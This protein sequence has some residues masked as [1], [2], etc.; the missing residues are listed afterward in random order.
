MAIKNMTDKGLSFP[1]IGIIRKG[2]KKE[3]NGPGKDLPYF[4]VDFAEHE[5]KSAADFAAGYA[6]KDTGLLQPRTIRIILP[7]NEI[8]RQ[9]DA[10]YE[11]YTAGRMVARSDGEKIIYQCA[12]DGT[13]L[14]KDG[15]EVATG[16]PKPHPE[17]MFAGNDYKGKGVKFKAV[18]RLNVIIPELKRAA[19]LTLQTTSIHDITNISAQLAGFSALNGGQIAGIPFYLRRTP[20]PVSV[21]KPDGTRVRMM[22]SLVSIEADPDWVALKLD[23]LKTLALPNTDLLLPASSETDLPVD[24]EIDADAEE[25]PEFDEAA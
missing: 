20:R 24:D 25:L 9:W 15:I 8:A 23:S 6:N 19:Y 3:P 5:K 18:G 22:K 7:F 4:R 10:W 16:L 1:Q 14:V 21:P 11:A 13:I 2:A 12:H 17:D